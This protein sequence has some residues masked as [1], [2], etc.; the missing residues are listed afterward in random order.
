MENVCAFWRESA[1]KSCGI[2][3]Q[4]NKTTWCCAGEAFWCIIVDLLSTQTLDTISW[5]WRPKGCFYSFINPTLTP[6]FLWWTHFPLRSHLFCLL[7][8]FVIDCKGWG[9]W[10]ENFSREIS[11]SSTKSCTHQNPLYYHPHP[12]AKLFL[13]LSGGAKSL[14]RIGINV[15]PSFFTLTQPSTFSNWPN[16]PLFIARK[17]HLGV[18]NYTDD[19]KI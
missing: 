13:I 10:M 6:N 17:F 3:R 19:W 4:M 2:H 14:P 5:L 15:R 8:Q 12:C 1:T 7:R 16:F 11:L 9:A 18:K